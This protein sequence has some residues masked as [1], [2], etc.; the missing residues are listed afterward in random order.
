MQIKLWHDLR[1]MFSPCDLRILFPVWHKVIFAP[2]I[3][4]CRSADF[5]SSNNKSSD[6]ANHID[7]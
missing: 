4:F 6:T 7:I 5:F 1:L 2:L 3:L